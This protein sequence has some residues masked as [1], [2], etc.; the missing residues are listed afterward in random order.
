[1]DPG[2]YVQITDPPPLR[3]ETRTPRRGSRGNCNAEA[4][5][6]G[7][8][9]RFSP[10]QF[11]TQPRHR[12]VRRPCTIPWSRHRPT[13]RHASTKY[14]TSH[15]TRMPRKLRTRRTTQQLKQGQPRRRHSQVRQSPTTRQLQ[16]TLPQK[17]TTKHKSRPTQFRL[18]RRPSQRNQHPNTR[19]QPQKPRQQHTLPTRTTPKRPTSQLRTSPHL[20]KHRIRKAP[21]RPRRN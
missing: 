2:H 5:R 8:R 6:G 1:M 16:H 14:H 3:S 15:P 4:G 21:P 13:N 20:H 12:Q 17:K 10:S 18:R 19:P 7:R 11:H 9:R